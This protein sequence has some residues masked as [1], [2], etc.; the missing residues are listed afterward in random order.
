MVLKSNNCIEMEA[1]FFF[2][3]NP[4]NHRVPKN[5]LSINLDKLFSQYKPSTFNPWKESQEVM[6]QAR[7]TRK[8]RS[9]NQPRDRSHQIR[10]R[11]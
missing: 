7:L 1:P 4:Q 2:H 6:L 8:N 9:M 11:G 10:S 5:Q 3:E